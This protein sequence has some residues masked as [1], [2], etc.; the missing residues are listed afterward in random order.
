MKTYL[1]TQISLNEHWY[2]Q[3]SEDCPLLVP[4]FENEGKGDKSLVSL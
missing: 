4:P 3:V 2:E 1:V